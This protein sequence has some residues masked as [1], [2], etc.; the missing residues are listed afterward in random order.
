[1]VRFLSTIHGSPHANPGRT[2]ERWDSDTRTYQDIVLPQIKLDY[3]AGM[4]W[5]DF[6]DFLESFV[7]IDYKFRRPYLVNYF[8]CFES[9]ITVSHQVCKLLWPQE[10]KTGYRT[11]Q[12]DILALCR[13]IVQRTGTIRRVEQKANKRTRRSG[14]VLAFNHPPTNQLPK[15]RCEQCKT[16]SIKKRVTTHPIHR[17]CMECGVTLCC[18]KCWIDWHKEL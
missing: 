4:I 3:D 9:A 1:M 8:W 12:D 17:G 13:D 18:A 10:Y 7:R 5:V 2:K 14:H 11:F 6:A 16:R 15:A